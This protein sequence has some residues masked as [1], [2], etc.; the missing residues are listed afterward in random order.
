MDP[1]AYQ[2]RPFGPMETDPDWP[3]DQEEEEDTLAAPASVP[4]R[5]G[6]GVSIRQVDASGSLAIAPPS[7]TPMP[8]PED[9]CWLC[10]D[11]MEFYDPSGQAWCSLCIEEA[12]KSEGWQDLLDLLPAA[13]KREAESHRQLAVYAA[14]HYHGAG[15]PRLALRWSQPPFHQTL[16]GADLFRVFAAWLAAPERW[17]QREAERQLERLVEHQGLGV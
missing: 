14:A 9:V 8:E 17:K 11:A 2:P 16:A 4:A 3:G 10:E 12:G 5:V 7:G 13:W 1:R 15:R 6:P